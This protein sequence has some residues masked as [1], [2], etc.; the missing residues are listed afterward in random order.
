[1][2]AIHPTLSTMRFCRV[3]DAAVVKRRYTLAALGQARDSGIRFGVRNGKQIDCCT[4]LLTVPEEMIRRG[5]R[6]QN[7]RSHRHI[8]RGTCDHGANVA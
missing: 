4:H 5:L 2:R 8:P 6:P 3:N 7:Y 1:M